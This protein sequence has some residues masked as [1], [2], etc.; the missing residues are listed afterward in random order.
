ME[1]LVS[2]IWVQVLALGDLGQFTLPRLF[3]FSIYLMDVI[4][5]PSRKH[6][7]FSEIIVKKHRTVKHWA[8]A[9]YNLE[10]RHLKPQTPKVFPELLSSSD[11]TH[12]W[13]V[14]LGCL[15]ATQAA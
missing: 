8:D 6:K 2:R 4:P 14:N 10:L 3:C 5:Q 9:G 12:N 11:S 1:L 15:E 7:G 13:S